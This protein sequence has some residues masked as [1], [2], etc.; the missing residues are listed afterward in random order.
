MVSVAFVSNCSERGRQP[1]CPGSLGASLPSSH[2]SPL[3]TWLCRASASVI[4]PT[5]V[6][7]SPGAWKSH[8]LRH[9]WGWVSFALHPSFPHPSPPSH[10]F[11]LWPHLCNPGTRYRGSGGPLGSLKGTALWGWRGSPLKQNFRARFSGSPVNSIL[12]GGILYSRTEAGRAACSLSRCFHSQPRLKPISFSLFPFLHLSF[13]P[14]LFFLL[15][16]KNFAESPPMPDIAL[17][18]SFRLIDQL[19]ISFSFL[20]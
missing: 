2:P 5:P 1:Q 15:S 14:F 4:L 7:C 19:L 18:A 11:C 20:M 17:A 12:P 6:S 3:L 10:P 9:G 8:W 16:L 13:L